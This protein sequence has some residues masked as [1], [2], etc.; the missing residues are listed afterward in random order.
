MEYISETLQCGDIMLE[1]LENLN[2]TSIEAWIDGQLRFLPSLTKFKV[3]KAPAR[4]LY[5]LTTIV[6]C[7]FSGT[8]QLKDTVV[9][10]FLRNGSPV[11][12]KAYSHLLFVSTYQMH[13]VVVGA[14]MN[15]TF[16][17]T[18]S[19]KFC[20]TFED[21]QVRETSAM[22]YGHS[23]FLSKDY[24]MLDGCNAN[25]TERDAKLGERL[26]S[27]FNAFELKQDLVFW[28]KYEP[29]VFHWMLVL[30]SGCDYYA[31]KFIDFECRQLQNR[32]DQLKHNVLMQF[33]YA[34][35]WLRWDL[36]PIPLEIHRNANNIKFLDFD[37]PLRFIYEHCNDHYPDAPS[38]LLDVTADMV[39]WQRPNVK[40]IQCDKYDCMKCPIAEGKLKV[41]IQMTPYLAVKTLRTHLRDVIQRYRQRYH[42]RHGFDVWPEVGSNPTEVEID[43]YIRRTFN[44]AG[45]P[46]RVH[47]EIA[48]EQFIRSTATRVV[49]LQLFTE[50]DYLIVKRVVLPLWKH[51]AEMSED[52]Y[53]P[54]PPKAATPA[55]RGVMDKPTSRPTLFTFDHITTK[56][57]FDEEFSKPPCVKRMIETCIGDKHIGN[58]ERVQ[59]FRFITAK[60]TTH[61]QAKLLCLFLFQDTNV[62]KHTCGSNPEEFWKHDIG[63]SF[64]YVLE[65]YT[66]RDPTCKS[67]IEKD[68]CVH[69]KAGVGDI[70]DLMNAATHVCTEMINKT[71]TSTGKYPLPPK[72]QIWSPVKFIQGLN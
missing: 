54:I 52:D 34:K 65:N 35:K 27:R 25:P 4:M 59:M 55:P 48:V 72:F 17:E 20:I 3:S 22:F 46:K 58:T 12:R 2:S 70:E 13:Q 40:C 45:R 29:F 16:E 56:E 8:E 51:M 32:L 50:L 18:M 63:R 44:E 6:H 5:E 62:F 67:W 49:D 41:P 66:K 7:E 14:L 69:A 23:L 9:F 31:E 37:D 28:S 61:D 39:N 47:A 42:T 36:T 1:T 10:D 21:L 15:S 53:T 33:E 11:Q 38:H 30:V 71:R 60:A 64:I 57:Q 26:L 19:K 43:A 68:I 24:Y